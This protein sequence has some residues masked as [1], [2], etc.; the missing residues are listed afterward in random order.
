VRYRLT[1]SLTL[2]RARSQSRF[3]VARQLGT[4]SVHGRSSV[5]WLI[6]GLALAVMACARPPVV[7]RALPSPIVAHKK[8]ELAPPVVDEPGGDMDGQAYKIGPG[9]AMLVAVY[10]HPELSIAAYAGQALNVA[11]GRASGL[12]VDN[13]GT[14]QFP[15]IGTVHVAGKTSA[16]L[17][18]FLE[19]QLAIYV[20]DPKVTVQVIFNGSIRYYFLGQFTNPG[21]KT[22]DRPM[23]L[24][25]ALTLGGSINLERASLRRAY[26]ARGG[27]RLTVNFQRL[28]REGDL[29]HN[30]RLKAGD[31]V[32]V[33]DN[34]AEVAFVF[35]G[36][37]QTA[38]QG[39]T[40]P[41]I[42]GSLDLLQALAGAGYGFRERVQGNL[43][44]TV[45]IR[46]ENDRG[47]LFVINAES[48]LKGEAG[49]FALA[50]GDVVFI[51]PTGVTRWNLALEQL[52]PTL[53]AINGVMNPFVQY[54]LLTGDRVFFN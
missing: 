16:Q 18:S 36:A 4:R 3:A 37:P 25:E 51:P 13:D 11:G 7:S 31:V 33:P 23:R 19:Q 46:S 20:K 40:V 29:R 22:I 2:L 32:F 27:K 35:G 52:L 47:E 42:N 8:D 44:K 14:A 5:R 26:I 28:I 17:R 21:M 53:T 34:A 38:A 1:K 41:F 12:V 48:M 9:D 6:L 54:K 49:S 15:L 45:V 39:R 43:A 10:G 30:I 50:P 24:L